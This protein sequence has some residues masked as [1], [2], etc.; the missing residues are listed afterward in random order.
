M[1]PSRDVCTKSFSYLA[2][3]G[4][5]PLEPTPTGMWSNI[6]WASCSFTGCTSLSSKFVRSKR[7]PQLMSNPTPPTSVEKAIELLKRACWW[8]ALAE[9]SSSISVPDDRDY[10]LTPV[11]LHLLSD[12]IL[13][14]KQNCIKLHFNRSTWSLRFQDSQKCSLAEKNLKT[15]KKKNPKQFFSLKHMLYRHRCTIA[16]RGLCLQSCSSKQTREGDTTVKYTVHRSREDVPVLLPTVRRKVMDLSMAPW[17]K[18][19]SKASPWKQV[20]FETSW[21]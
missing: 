3:M 8:W 18:M 9:Y 16:Y 17:C 14:K 11:I 13:G 1:S 6:A 21:E 2:F 5:T 10:I 7:T 20:I 15:L 19:F 4:M 12:T